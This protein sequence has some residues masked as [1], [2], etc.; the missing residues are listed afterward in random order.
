[1]ESPHKMASLQAVQH[2][3]LPL[4][5]RVEGQPTR[6]EYMYERSIMESALR[7]FLI[8]EMIQR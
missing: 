4:E 5:W 6:A 1:M 7:D 8:T 2:P 3:N